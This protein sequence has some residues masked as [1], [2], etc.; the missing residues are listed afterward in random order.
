MPPLV[1]KQA[2]PAQPASARGGNQ[3]SRGG[4]GAA[5]IP[6]GR[7]GAAATA[8]S[9]QQTPFAF[10]TP[11]SPQPGAASPPNVAPTQRIAALRKFLLFDVIPHEQ[12]NKQRR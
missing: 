8:A 9:R 4:G 2:Q 10:P 12:L 6:S 11:S 7:G 3:A 1:P 5:P